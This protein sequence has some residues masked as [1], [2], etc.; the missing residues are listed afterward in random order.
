MEAPV[1]SG[2]VPRSEPRARRRV[3]A[4]GAH[5]SG[6]WMCI[7]FLREVKGLRARPHSPKRRNA[8]GNPADD[9]KDR[10]F[11]GMC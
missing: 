4:R 3:D 5:S 11:A 6:T 9:G 10:K 2:K 7:S 8:G 1:T